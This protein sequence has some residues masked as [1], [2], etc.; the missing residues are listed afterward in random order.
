VAATVA[1][2]AETGAPGSAVIW[3]LSSANNRMLGRSARIYADVADAAA[4]LR[5]NIQHFESWKIKFVGDEVRGNY[6]WYASVDHEPVMI[7]A[8][9][10]TTERDR[11]QALDL[12]L[13]SIVVAEVQTGSRLV[14][15]A[16]RGGSR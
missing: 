6:G 8:R 4:S 1:P 5:S 11:R 7:C 16:A 2:S 14:G 12:A 9:W 3:H 13:D 15:A 10:Y